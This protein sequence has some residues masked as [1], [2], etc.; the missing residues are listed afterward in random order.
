VSLPAFILSREAE[1]SPRSLC[2][3]PNR[4]E[5]ASREGSY[6]KT[7]VRSPSSI[8][9]L[10]ETSLLRRA[11][12]VQKHQSFLDRIPFDFH[13]QPGGRAEPQTTVYLPH[14]RKACLPTGS[15]LT[16]RTQERAGLP[17]MLPEANRLTGETSSSQ[18][19]LEQLTPEI[20]RW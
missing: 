18:R 1:L 9:G 5:L 12:R 4:G 19:Q 2:N 7:Q 16:P 13:P 15:A 6:L 17:G 20:T 11:L 14:Q 10:S 3:F 8:P